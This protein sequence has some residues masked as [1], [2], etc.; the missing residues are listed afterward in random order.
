MAPKI[1]HKRLV[2]KHLSSK[3]IQEIFLSQVT[4]PEELLTDHL[5]IRLVRE[6]QQVGSLVTLAGD[7]LDSTVVDPQ[8]AIYYD[9]KGGM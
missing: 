4:S 8:I 2:R 9:G 7:D 3:A 1:I 6:T 5:R